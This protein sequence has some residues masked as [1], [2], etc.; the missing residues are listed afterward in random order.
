MYK[1]AAYLFDKDEFGRE[2]G[3]VGG[4]G[5]RLVEGRRELSVKG[6]GHLISTSDEIE[7]EYALPAL[8]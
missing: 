4:G 7:P 1:K 5:G 8:R 6:N 3:G 2:T